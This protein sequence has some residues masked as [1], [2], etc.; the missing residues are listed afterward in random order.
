MWPIPSRC[1]ADVWTGIRETIKNEGELYGTKF[2]ASAIS[3]E[4]K[5]Y[6]DHFDDLISAKAKHLGITVRELEEKLRNGD[7]NLMAFVLASP[8]GAALLSGA[9]GG[10]APA[11]D[12]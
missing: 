9:L 10:G 4:S 7:A 3:G 2:K 8:F 5:S 12:E 11:Q 6:A 1:S